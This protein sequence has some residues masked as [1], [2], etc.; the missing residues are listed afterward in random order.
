MARLPCTT[1]ACRLGNGLGLVGK[2]FA[3]NR[4]LL[5]DLA[6]RDLLNA[7]GFNAGY[8]WVWNFLQRAKKINQGF[9]MF[10]LI[11]S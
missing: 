4:G 7:S 11:R 5:F 2:L 6:W 9:W 8:L 1:L 10:N 3:E